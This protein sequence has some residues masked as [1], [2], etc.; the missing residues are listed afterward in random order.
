MAV[1]GKSDGHSDLGEGVHSSSPFHTVYNLLLVWIGRLLF[2][3]L[4][5]PGFKSFLTSLPLTF[6]AA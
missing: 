2:H 3:S 6:L 4:I 1:Q 5:K